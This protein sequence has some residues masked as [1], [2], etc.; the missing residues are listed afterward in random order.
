MHFALPSSAALRPWLSYSHR[1]C[2]NPGT[3]HRRFSTMQASAS[4]SEW[5][6]QDKRRMLH[7]V[8]R[9]GDMQVNEGCI[10][11]ARAS[12][13]ARLHWL[14][15]AAA[16]AAWSVHAPRLPWPQAPPVPWPHAP[17]LSCHPLL[18]FLTSCGPCPKPAASS[19]DATTAV[20]GRPACRHTSI[21]TP[22]CWA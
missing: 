2:A 16:L 15:P 21:T 9:V 19:P 10:I 3:L 8:Y 4:A 1:G 12:V 7:V 11:G 20:G 17:R 18:A 13:A 6:K 14:Q 22:S 5:T